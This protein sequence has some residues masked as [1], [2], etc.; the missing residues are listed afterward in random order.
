MNMKPLRN[1]LLLFGTASVSFAGV[2]TD[3]AVALAKTDST[4]DQVA[5]KAAAAV[6]AND[7]TPSA[8]L[9]AVLAARS[10]WSGDQVAL[11]YRSV[12]L[13]SGLSADL[14]ENLAAYYAE[15][16]KED[17][18]EGV[19]LLGILYQQAPAVA[20]AVVDSVL[21]SAVVVPASSAVGRQV[22]N[23]VT[24]SAVENVSPAPVVP[25]PPPVSSD[26]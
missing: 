8:V 16:V 9:A 3:D 12:L 19:K 25:T 26:N 24:N 22:N 7:A 15:G 4:I 2:L 6:T 14:S 21:G 10:T 17:S 11:I 23:P 1:A 18:S 20:N 13:A 5:E